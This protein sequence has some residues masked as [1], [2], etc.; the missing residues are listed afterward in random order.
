MWQQVMNKAGTNDFGD[1]LERALRQQN[2]S[3]K[4]FAERYEIPESTLY[5]IT[6]GE[7]VNFGVETLRKIA[8]GLQ[9]EEGYDQRTVGLITT[10]Q[11]CDQ[12]PSEMSF[13]ETT[14]RI[15][16]LPAHTIEEEIIKGVNAEKDGIDAI[17]CGPI[18]ATTIEQVVDIPVSGLQF[19][20]QLMEDSLQ[21]LIERLN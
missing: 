14:Y 18:A 4:E 15:L 16:P 19:D 1:Q 10:R 6:S 5:K 3:I 17:L 13:Q 7:R 11:A 21:S 20:K 12:A 8:D 2:L 9:A